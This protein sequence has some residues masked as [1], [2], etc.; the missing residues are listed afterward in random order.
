MRPPLG[1][2]GLSPS[3]A[4]KPDSTASY[5]LPWAVRSNALIAAYSEDVKQSIMCLKDIDVFYCHSSSPISIKASLTN[6][7]QNILTAFAIGHL[8]IEE[9]RSSSMTISLY[10][11]LP[12]KPRS[13]KNRSEYST[14]TAVPSVTCEQSET[15][16]LP[17]TS[18]FVSVPLVLACS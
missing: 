2:I 8:L 6:P 15:P 7:R 3:K 14:T 9:H 12:L 16:S 11:S 1:L 18:G 4:I 5:S 10:N 17:P 13:A